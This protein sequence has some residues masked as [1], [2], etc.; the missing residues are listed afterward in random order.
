MLTCFDRA[1]GWVAANPLTG[2]PHPM[3]T[4]NRTSCFLHWLAGM[5]FM[6]CISAFVGML[7]GIFRPGVLWFL[8]DPTDPAFHPLKSMLEYRLHH[9]TLRMV[10]V[11]T[12]NNFV[13]LLL[14]WAP[15]KAVML[16]VPSL[17][18]YRAAM[19]HPLELLAFNLVVPF[20]QV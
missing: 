4:A 18:P 16:L 1:V 6:H 3:Q 10:L 17:L 14:V 8:R 2:S 11:Q 5:I 7:R 12:M 20:I 13:V 9:Y 15:I 19:Y